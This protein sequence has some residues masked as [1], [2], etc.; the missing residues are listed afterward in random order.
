MYAN[1]VVYDHVNDAAAT[2][3]AAAAAADDDDDG[4]TSVTV[5]L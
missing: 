3:A 2:A 4:M 1:R 5:A